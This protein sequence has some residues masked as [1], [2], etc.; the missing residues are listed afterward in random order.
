MSNYSSVKMP[1]P[2]YYKQ[3]QGKEHRVYPTYLQHSKCHENINPPTITPTRFPSGMI[4]LPFWQLYTAYY[5]IQHQISRHFQQNHRLSGN[6]PTTCHNTFVNIDSDTWLDTYLDLGWI[7]W[8]AGVGYL[9]RKTTCFKSCHFLRN[10]Y[11]IQWHNVFQFILL[12]PNVHFC[13]LCE[14]W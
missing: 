1:I 7:I 13:C 9:V 8:C 12:F 14:L 4:F 6:Y 3:T 5:T 11:F 10:I 2:P